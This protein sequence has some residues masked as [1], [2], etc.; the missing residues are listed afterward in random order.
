MSSRIDSLSRLSCEERGCAGKASPQASSTERE[1]HHTR[2]KS[3]GRRPSVDMEVDDEVSPAD[4]GHRR[5]NRA[6]RRLVTKENPVS[7]CCDE[8]ADYFNSPCTIKGSVENT[9][10]R[11][12]KESTNHESLWP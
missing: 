4:A 6:S 8:S 12:A 9:N 10:M 1:H 7:G 3:S 5:R 11:T 2:G